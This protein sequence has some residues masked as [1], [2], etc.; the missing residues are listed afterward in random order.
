MTIGL[1]YSMVWPV[2]FLR[3]GKGYLAIY[4]P[5]SRRNIEKSTEFER[6]EARILKIQL[7]FE[8]SGSSSGAKKGIFLG[9]PRPFLFRFVHS[10]YSSKAV[11]QP[12]CWDDE[13]D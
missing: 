3:F 5:G 6:S 13:C 1:D 11:H 12:C 4:G 7:N 2:G 10:A 9:R 8:V